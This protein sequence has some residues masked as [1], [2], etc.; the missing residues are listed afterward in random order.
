MTDRVR[1]FAKWS[2][3]EKA[4]AL[5]AEIQAVLVEY[6]AYA[7]LTARQIYYRL[8]GRGVIVKGDKA[9]DKVEDVLNRARRSDRIGFDEI[10]DDGL[11]EHSNLYFASPDDAIASARMM[12]DN[13]LLDPMVD[14]PRAILILCEA[15][16]MVPMV[17]A[18]ANRY[19]VRVLSSGG[20]DSTTVKY[21][22]AMRLRRL[23]QSCGGPPL[24][25]HIGDYDPSGVHLFNALKEDVL[26]FLTDPD[27]PDD[28]PAFHGEFRRLAVTEEQI[29]DPDL[30]IETQ[31]KNPADNRSF[32]GVN[33]DGVTTA[34]A[35][36][37]A[38]DDFAAIVRNAIRA[39]IDMRTLV[40][41]R[42][43]QRADIEELHARLPELFGSDDR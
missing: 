11:V 9:K 36:A 41:T 21:D 16:G 30:A 26:A 14:Q 43:R 28:H 2:P 17:S 37:I 6:R 5:L 4:R 27:D 8:I 34:Q 23:K 38:P 39:E 12:L 7:P 10:R 13:Y 22:L 18:L 3:R 35:E 24:V 15:A 19:G 33:G 25:F 31:P 1:G 40:L 32:D 20:F 29:L 42:R